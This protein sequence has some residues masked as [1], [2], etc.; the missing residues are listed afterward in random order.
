[1]RLRLRDWWLKPVAPLILI[2]VVKLGIQLAFNSSLTSDC[3][4][5][6]RSVPVKTGSTC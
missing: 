5:N 4:L 2:G 6:W 3:W 1:V